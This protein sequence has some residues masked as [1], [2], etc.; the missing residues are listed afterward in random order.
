MPRV[1][2]LP[3]YLVPSSSDDAQWLKKAVSELCNLK[4]KS[5]PLVPLRPF[6]L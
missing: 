5:D 2:D 4:N 1:P 3:G 6:R